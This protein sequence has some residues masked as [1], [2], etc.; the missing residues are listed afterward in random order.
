M[1]NLIVRKVVEESLN[2]CRVMA[3][4]SLDP[5][6]FDSFIKIYNTLIERRR[7]QNKKIT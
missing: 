6:E 4:E 3:E 2:I 7:L 1:D 5:E